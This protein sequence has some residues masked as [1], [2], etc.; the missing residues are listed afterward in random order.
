MTCVVVDLDVRAEHDA[1]RLSRSPLFGWLAAHGLNPFL[2][3][4][5]QVWAD[6]DGTVIADCFVRDQ[7]AR[8]RTRLVDGRQEL[9]VEV[10]VRALTTPIPA[11]VLAA[12]RP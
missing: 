1:G 5:V 12:G 6:G 4:R 8:L 9:M 11:A 10:R 2:V 3:R 7:Y